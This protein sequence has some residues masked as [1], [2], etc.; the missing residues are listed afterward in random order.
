MEVWV[1]M[2]EVFPMYEIS[3][4]GNVRNMQT[5]KILKPR[6]TGFF[7]IVFLRN[8]NNLMKWVQVQDLLFEY[9]ARLIENIFDNVTNYLETIEDTNNK[10]IHQWMV[11]H[12][13]TDIVSMDELYNH[14]KNNY[15]KYYAWIDEDEY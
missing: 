10:H 2:Y 7:N 6:T 12:Y 4:N 3:S 11:K 14:A 9:G 15:E 1:Q 13:S 5:N 8:K